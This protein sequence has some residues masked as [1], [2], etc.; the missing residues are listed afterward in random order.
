MK[1]LTCEMCGSVDLMKK[2]GVFVCQS[3]G[4]KYSVEEARKM[5]VEGTVE[6]TGTVKVDNTAQI[7]EQI[8]N[9]LDMAKT[10]FEGED[11]EGTVR[12]CDRVLEIDRDS[13]EAWVLKAKAAGWGSTLN[14]IKVP[15]ALTAAKRAVNLAPDSEKYDVAEEVYQSI[16]LQIIALLQIAQRMPGASGCEYIQTIMLQWQSVLVGIPYLSVTVMEQE[17]KDCQELCQ[18]SKSAFAPSAR[19]VYSAYLAYNHNQS[20][21]KMFRDALEDKIK[22]E[23]AREQEFVKKEMEAAEQRTKAYWSEHADEKTALETEKATL[24]DKIASLRNEISSIPGDTEKKNIQE[25]IDALSVEKSSLGLFKGKEKKAIQEKI[26]A[27]NFEL[28]KVIDRMDTAKK[29]IEKK[30]VMAQQ[31]IDAIDIELT[32]A[33]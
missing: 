5:M 13:Y 22:S 28:K 3:C 8:K 20:Y 17:I 29:E 14:N 19:L 10:A 33:R 31:R 4:C 18:N 25:C 32:K 24:Q 11:I 27:A 9:Y 2:E 6:V 1:Q 12:Y 21:D 23:K 7:N 15:Q 16:K 30:I 26:D